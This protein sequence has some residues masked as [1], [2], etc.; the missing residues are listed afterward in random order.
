MPGLSEYSGITEIQKQNKMKIIR[1]T[2]ILSFL[3]LR[4]TFIFSQE[5]NL[6][7]QKAYAEYVKKDYNNAV[8]ILKDDN[9]P[10]VKADRYLM[11]KGDA[12]FKLKDFENALKYYKK[13]FKLKNK[14]AALKIAECFAETNQHYKAVEYL[15]IYL[16]Y[17]D[18]LLPSEV[19]LLPSFSN[20]ENEKVWIN[21][22]KE[23]HYN[24]YEQKLD[25]AKYQISKEN[26]AEAF[27]I[28]DKLII[29]NQ[30]R[31]RAFEMRGDLLMLT[32]DPKA[33][34]NSYLKASKIKKRNLTY[35][36]KA[37][38]AYRLAGKNKIAD[39][40]YT[41]I[42]NND[43]YNPEIL[44]DK[45]KN[46]IKLKKYDSAKESI[47]MFLSFFPDNAEA[48]FI[49]GKLS[50]LQ[51][52]Y[53]NALEE[54]NESI[55]KD[56]SKY[57]YF[58]YCGDAYFKTKTYESAV[59][60]YLMALDLNPKLPEVWYKKGIA[61]IKQYKYKEACED[62]KKAKSMN[63]NKADDYLIKYCK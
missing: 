37:A 48:Y 27:D 51:S 35:K 14:T 30:K 19:K 63:Y 15:K 28:L 36:T 26:F 24:S 39:K 23:K 20:S 40:I 1:L 59:N 47:D 16:K 29:K 10:S 52:E 4:T 44:I 46:D 43:F 11:L 62:L 7:Y 56:Q 50:Y 5:K 31:H 55:K 25:E 22:W 54:L 33:A 61:E 17:P 38:N 53:I 9:L 18:K 21:F 3:I 45:A 8:N 57:K 6:I 58:I 49:K 32:R 41:G 42:I 34:A 13:A 60:N 2:Y 12:Y